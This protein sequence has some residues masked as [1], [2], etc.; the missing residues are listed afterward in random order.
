M[1]YKSLRYVRAEGPDTA[2]LKNLSPQEISDNRFAGATMSSCS[3][4]AVNHQ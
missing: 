1:K 2:H 3:E 4:I